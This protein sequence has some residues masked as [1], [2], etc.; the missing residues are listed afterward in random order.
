MKRIAL[1]AAAVLSLP[2]SAHAALVKSTVTATNGV[3]IDKATD[4]FAQRFEY[5]SPAQKIQISDDTK[6]VAFFQ[7]IRK[8][9]V[10][11][12]LTVEG[13]VRYSSRNWRHYRTAVFAGGEPAP[14]AIGS[15]DVKMCDRLCFMT[16]GFFIDLTADQIAKYGK[17]GAVSVQLRSDSGETALVTLPVSHFAA[18]EEVAK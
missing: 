18:M 13:F 7:R 8:G 3:V 15:K 4:D 14:F 1:I 16:E 9:E 10:L 12:K 6:V 5:T 17:D 11:D 2:M